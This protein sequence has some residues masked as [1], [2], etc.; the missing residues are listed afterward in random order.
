MLYSLCSWQKN[1]NTIHN[2]SQQTT[3]SC[4]TNCNQHWEGA[5][6]ADWARERGHQLERCFCRDLYWSQQLC[7]AEALEK[8]ITWRKFHLNAMQNWPME[9]ENKGRVCPAFRVSNWVTTFHLWNIWRISLDNAQ[10]HGM[11]ITP[12]ILNPTSVLFNVGTIFTDRKFVSLALIWVYLSQ[13]EGKVL[14]LCTMYF[15]HCVD[16]E[17][18]KVMK[19]WKGFV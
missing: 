18:I 8:W 12:G 15:A 4:K 1:Q 19:R 13:K 5:A 3:G 7:D 17:S 10:T 11:H 16:L 14:L 6:W 9:S 2:H